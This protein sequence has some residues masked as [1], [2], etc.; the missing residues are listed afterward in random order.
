MRVGGY[1]ENLEMLA[2]RVAFKG[3]YLASPHLIPPEVR[4]LKRKQ[5]GDIQVANQAIAR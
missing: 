3:H 1:G 2:R 4:A 5:S